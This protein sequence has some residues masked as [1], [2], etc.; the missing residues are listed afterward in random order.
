MARCDSL[1]E[2]KSII[3]IVSSCSCKLIRLMFSKSFTKL[4]Y[5]SYHHPIYKKT[6]FR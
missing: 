6:S 1:R 3:E 5:V 4:D 2:L